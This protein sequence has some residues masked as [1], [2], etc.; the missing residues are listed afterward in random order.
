MGLVEI[1]IFISAIIAMYNIQQIKM[2][3]K[4]KGFLVD[5]FTGWLRDYRQF[6]DLIIKETDQVQKLRYQRILNG[7][8]VS[9]IGFAGLLVLHLSGRI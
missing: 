7:L 8:H 1:A 5:P 3:L 6:K 2:T 4:E 9:L